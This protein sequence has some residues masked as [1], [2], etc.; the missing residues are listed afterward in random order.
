M[1]KI[2]TITKNLKS[3]LKKKDQIVPNDDTI[4]KPPIII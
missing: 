1:L 3:I 4:A 2:E